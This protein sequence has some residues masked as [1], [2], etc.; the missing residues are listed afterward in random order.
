MTWRS[1][2]TLQQRV[3]ACL[4][5]LIPMLQV[6]QLGGLVFSLV[7]PLTLVF[8]P[9]FL[10]APIYF[11]SL[12]GFAIGPLIVFFALFLLV[13]QN[14]K[15]AHFIRFNTLQAIMI[16]LAAFLLQIVL[17]FFGMT[18]QALSPLGGSNSLFMQILVTLI[19]LAA[20]GSSIYAIVQCLRGRY[21]EIPA[22][23]E[24]VYNQVR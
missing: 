21:A 12:G 15:V 9:L 3:L 1:S 11:F 17:E 5:Y 10:I 20:T 13:V 22:I 7:P 23:S 24:A 6:L 14:Y 18:Q 8:F 16:S 4:P 2:T 19:Y